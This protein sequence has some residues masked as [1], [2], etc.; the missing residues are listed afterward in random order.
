[1]V[2]DSVEVGT[3][4]WAI[5]VWMFL[6]FCVLSV[7]SNATIVT[8]LVGFDV[9]FRVGQFPLCC[10]FVVRMLSMN[11][12]RWCVYV[13][14]DILHCAIGFRFRYD[15]CFFMPICVM[16]HT[17]VIVDFVRQFSDVS[18]K[19]IQTSECSR[20]DDRLVG[21]QGFLK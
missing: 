9:V 11:D 3:S 1:M 10:C 17:H 14:H 6:N 4:N 16:R 5:Y 19:H 15:A 8:F 18:Q 7:V 21:H 20:T 12:V 13:G 2:I